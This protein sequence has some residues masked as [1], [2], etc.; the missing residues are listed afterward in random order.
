MSKRVLFI[1][2]PSGFKDVEFDTPYTMIKDAGH[3]VDVAGL[4]AD[5]ATGV[6]GMLFT[7][8]LVLDEISPED[9]ATY[10]IVVIPGGP[11]STRHLW[12]NKKVQKV[13]ST[14]HKQKKIV[15]TICFGCIVPVQAGILKNK[16]AT[17]YPTDESLEV[18]KQQ[19]VEYVDEGCVVLED[20][21]IITAQG[22][23]FAKDFAQAILDLLTQ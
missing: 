19:E 2:I 13:V 6:D 21:K 9:L 23:S 4:I 22:P 8:N 15:A 10:D 11:G 3:H 20:E 1:L 17:I 16:K 12:D 18:L 14:F 5:E 7:P